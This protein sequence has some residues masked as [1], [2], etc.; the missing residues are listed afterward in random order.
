MPRVVVV[1]VDALAGFYW[2]DAR[3][4]MPTLRALAAR[5]ALAR[6]AESVFPS[7]TWPSHA[8]IVTGVRPRRHGVVANS[9]LNRAT[10][11]AED[12]T[13]DPIYDAA[14]L[15]RAPALWDVARRAGLESAAID[16]PGTRHAAALGWSGEPFLVRALSLPV[17][18]PDVRRGNVKR[19]RRAL[20]VHDY[21]EFEALF[22]EHGAPPP[23]RVF[24]VLRVA[25]A[26]V[27]ARGRVRRPTR[28]QVATHLGYSSGR[29][30]GRQVKRLTGL[31]VGELLRVPVERL[32]ERLATSL[33]G[34]T[35]QAAGG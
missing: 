14:D 8:T 13:G 21:G 1:S 30:L 18:E 4:R 23:K 10:G 20:G 2:S 11:V 34:G 22:R 26:A 5:G 25:A 7:T 31:T 24:D 35:D 16:W 27:W 9:I 33:R 28:T 6:R 12:L 29:Y 3:A 19:W 17:L 32:V 15:Y